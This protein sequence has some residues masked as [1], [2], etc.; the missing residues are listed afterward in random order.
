MSQP[1]ELPIVG[2]MRF[3]SNKVSKEDLLGY[4]NTLKAE[5]KLKIQEKT[6]FENLRRNESNVFEVATSR[7]VITARKVILALG[8]RGSPRKLGILNEGM[9][10]VTYNLLDPEQYQKQYLCVVGG[11]N[12]AAEAAQYLARAE[13]GNNTLLVVRGGSLNKANEENV[14]L[15]NTLERQGR[16]KIWYNSSVKEIHRD[17]IIVQKGNDLVNVP[18]NYVF[19]FAGAEMP[20]DFLMSLGIKIDKKHGEK[21]KRVGGK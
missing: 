20:F 4:W 1:A 12:A 10:K 6:K 19:I 8:V 18:N 9:P 11:G 13:Y 5:H 2:K 14:S 3:R 15:V 16:L 21:L 7:G 17:Y